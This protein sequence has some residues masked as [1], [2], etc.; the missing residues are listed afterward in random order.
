VSRAD[1]SLFRGIVAYNVPARY[2]VLYANLL[3]LSCDGVQIIRAIRNRWS[4]AESWKIDREATI[5][6]GNPLDHRVPQAAV[7][8][9]AVK[10]NR[11]AS[12]LP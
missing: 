5:L 2:T 6:V 11:T 7:R 10:M 1:I 3:N 8:G 12:P 9:H 4:A